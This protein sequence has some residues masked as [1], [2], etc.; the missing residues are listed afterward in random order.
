M[1]N[2]RQNIVP[3][4]DWRNRAGLRRLEACRLVGWSPSTLDRNIRGGRIRANK[5]GGSV[6]IP[7]SEIARI[8]GEPAP[9]P[10]PEVTA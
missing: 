8:L 6:L 2:A 3:L 9:A 7:V 1:V 4:A 10:I 5:V